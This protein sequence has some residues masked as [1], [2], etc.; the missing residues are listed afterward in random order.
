MVLIPIICI[1]ACTEADNMP[2]PNIIIMLADDLGYGDVSVNGSVTIHTPNIDRLANGGIRFI[3]GYATSATSASSRYGL[4][5]GIYPWKNKLT[6]NLFE[7]QSLLI[8][9]SQYTLPKMLQDAGYTTATVGKWHLGMGNGN[10]NWNETVKPGA[11]EVGFDYSHLIAVNN[12]LTPTVYV[13][14][15]NVIGLNPNDPI[16]VSYKNELTIAQSY[17]VH[18]GIPRKG[19]QKGG[20]SALWA[21]EAMAEYFLQVATDF[22]AENTDRPFFLLYGLHQP[23]VPRVPNKRFTG[24]SG[25]GPRGD[26]IL[27]ADWCV[28]ELMKVLDK[29]HLLENTVIIFTSDNGPVLND[30][31]DDQA[32]ELLGKHKPAGELRGGKY[33]LYD[34]GTRVPFFT[35]WKGVIKPDV[36]KA[37]VSQLDIMASIATLI[38][39]PLSGSFDSQNVLSA[40]LGKSKKGRN[41]LVL[42]ATGKMALRCGDWVY[43]PAYDGPVRNSSGNELG[44]LPEGG[45]FDLKHDPGQIR[46]LAFV[47]KTR[48]EKMK[49]R[50]QEIIN[51]Q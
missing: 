45:L 31:Y 20:E 25:M 40:L 46:N 42:E 35:Y 37:L 50:F 16:E 44:N 10:T 24:L 21:D 48:L 22:I 29:L 51:D 5:T 49:L 38:K 32:V 23:G 7:N 43:M 14:N 19:L 26:A 18:N 13:E 34:A 30:G 27:E 47:E 12:D 36:S 17:T 3:N 39:Q 28:G 4:L 1:T 9:E 2:K 33:S 8:E 6:N 15:G 11:K 41:D